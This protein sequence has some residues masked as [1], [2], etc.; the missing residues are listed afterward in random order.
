MKQFILGL[1]FVLCLPLVLG[2]SSASYSIDSTHTGVTGA[3]GNAP[4]LFQNLATH[5]QT[6]GSFTSG[7]YE[8]NAGFFNRTVFIVDTTSFPSTGEFDQGAEGATNF[9]N[10]SNLRAVINPTIVRGGKGK[11]QFGG[12]KDARNKN[13][14]SAIEMG[15]GFVSVNVSLLGSQYNASSIISLDGV[16]CPFDGTNLIYASGVFT[17]LAEIQAV[18]ETCP[19]EICSNVQCSGGTLTFTA[20]HFTGFATQGNANLTIN[21]SAEGTYASTDTEVSFYAKYLNVTDGSPIPSATCSVTFDDNPTSYGMTWN[22]TGTNVYNFTKTAGF[23]SAATHI[24]NVTCSKTGFTT[25]FANDTIEIQ[26]VASS[27][28]ETSNQTGKVNFTQAGA[29]GIVLQDAGIAF[30]SGYFN[31]SCS[32]GYSILDSS[33]LFNAGENG[34]YAAPGCWINTS[35]LDVEDEGVSP[36]QDYHWLQNNGSTILSISSLADKDGPD[37]ICNRLDG[38]VCTVASANLS[39]KAAAN[40]TSACSQGLNNTYQLM[41]A[42]GIN[43]TIPLCAMLHFADTKDDLKVYY[44]LSIPSDIPPG[45]KTMTITY[46]ATAL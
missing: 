19:S 24:W 21:D 23:A 39:V 6:G 36:A 41:G 7:F 46:T 35:A 9:S 29:A 13:F 45:F 32:T 28:G 14:D 16:T 26:G 4:Y 17:T 27:S 34:A 42:D 2:A 25:L 20:A 30:G 15:A 31:T 8:G 37:F 40:E 12:T 10:V 44:K 5:Q 18:G 33:S 11:I 43:N 22:G 3:E 38:G 1:I